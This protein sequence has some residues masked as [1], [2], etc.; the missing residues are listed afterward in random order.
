[1]GIKDW[2]KK[3]SKFE[4]EVKEI[5]GEF[6]QKYV[7]AISGDTFEFYAHERVPGFETHVEVADAFRVIG[8]GGGRCIRSGSKLVLAD[9]S[10]VYG[11]VPEKVLK[12]FEEL[13]LEAYKEK[14]PEIEGID[15]VF[16]DQMVDSR[17]WSDIVDKIWFL[18][19]LPYSFR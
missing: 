4:Y 5:V 3:K 19:F 2:F 9:P 10:G 11:A 14:F 15:I 12:G 6:P 1:M 7:V 16:H 13:L 18:F 8:M 17:R